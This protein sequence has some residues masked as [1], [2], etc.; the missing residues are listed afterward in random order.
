MVGWHQRHEFEQ[1]LGDG[2]GQESLVCCSP[3]GLK[4]WDKTQ[5]LNNNIT[6]LPEHTYPESFQH[7]KAEA[8][9]VLDKKK[10]TKKNTPKNCYFKLSIKKDPYYTE[11]VFRNTHQTQ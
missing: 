2:E 7:Y 4:E 11:W 1:T 8:T 5:R 6:E 3:W 9:T 10:K